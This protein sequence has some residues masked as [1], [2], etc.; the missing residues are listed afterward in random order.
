MTTH[1]N[2]PVAPTSGTSKKSGAIDQRFLTFSL[3]AESY[4]VPLPKVREVIAFGELT[5]IPNTPPYFRGIM[6]LRGQVISVIDLRI[7]F[8]LPDAAITPET[9][10]I[11]LDM[12]SLCLGIIIDSVDAVLSIPSDS[13]SPP[14]DHE[15]AI[16]LDY[17]TGVARVNKSLILTLDI[18]KALSVEDL[19]AM[20]RSD[21]SRDVA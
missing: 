7:K 1:F 15:S 2:L 18:E 13:I 14:P 17:V 19:V 12:Q 16:G 4:A 20:R 3:G 21:A 9:A 10:I 5:K 8:Q 6:N 11:I